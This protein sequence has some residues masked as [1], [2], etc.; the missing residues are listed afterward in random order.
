[1]EGV[2]QPVHDCTTAVQGDK[3]FL[4]DAHLAKRAC[5]A[6]MSSKDITIPAAEDGQPDTTIKAVK[7]PQF[8]R[9]TQSIFNTQ[10]EKRKMSLTT[11]E[12]KLCLKLDPTMNLTRLFNAGTIGGINAAYTAEFKK[13]ANFLVSMPNE[14]R[15][16]CGFPLRAEAPANKRPS[17]KQNN[18]KKKKKKSAPSSSTEDFR[19]V[20]SSSEEEEE[21]PEPQLHTQ[22]PHQQHMKEMKLYSEFL[23]N[24]EALKPYYEEDKKGK[25]TFNILKFWS[26]HLED[27]P[28]HCILVRR[29]YCVL[30]TEAN[31]ERHFSLGGNVVTDLRSTLHPDHVKWYVCPACAVQM[32]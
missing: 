19:M 28:V 20:I 27:M 21:M 26:D 22:T 16:R 11:H 10:W 25:K 1:M 32:K 6:K 4:S 5:A 12:D 31:I 17:A 7:M 30:P 13:A 9:D 8:L 15:K 2:M 18:K 24:K 29:F 23:L 14:I 3:T